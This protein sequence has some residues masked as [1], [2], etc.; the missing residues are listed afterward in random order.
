VG[1][2][3][4]DAPLAREILARP[5][6]LEAVFAEPLPP[7]VT[8][9]AVFATTDLVVAPEGSA[10]PGA[11]TATVDATHVSILESAPAQG[12]VRDILAG[13]PVEGAS[14]LAAILAPALPAW[15]PPASGA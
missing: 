11:P 10:V 9:A 8:A 12:V 5:E 2:F 14:P 6:G 13:R 7:Q 1:A 3:D 15:L 4:P